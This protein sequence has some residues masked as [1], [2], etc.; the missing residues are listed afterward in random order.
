MGTGRLG[1]GDDDFRHGLLAGTGVGGKGLGNRQGGGGYCKFSFEHSGSKNVGAS[2]EGETAEGI[3]T[4][5]SFAGIIQI[6][7]GGYLSPG[8]FLNGQDP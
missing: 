3:I 1:A 2:G 6:R 4:T 5:L 8:R 7:Y